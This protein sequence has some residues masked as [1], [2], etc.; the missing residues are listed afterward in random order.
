MGGTKIDV[1]LANDRGDIKVRTLRE[2]CA[3]EGRDLVIDRIIDAI[4]QV[5]S[6]VRVDA[7]GIGAAGACEFETGVITYSPNLPGWYNISL[8]SL[9]EAKVGLP[10]YLD[11]DAAVAAIGEHTFGAGIGIDHMILVTLGTGI[12]G[13]I[14][15]NGELYRGASGSAGEIGHMTIDLNGPRCS[16]GKKGCW[17]VL[18]SG[19]ALEREATARIE[20][21]EET[22]IERND[23]NCSAEVSARS[24]HKAALSGDR[25]ANELIALTSYYLGI[26]LVNLVNIFNPQLILIGGGLSN[27]G[28]MLID[29]AVETVREHAF[30]I[31]AKAARVEL[32]SLGGDA[33]P[34]GAV[35]LALRNMAR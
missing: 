20:A 35:A 12:G 32:S 15:I 11:N 22:S 31:S 1:V 25:L 5:S 13:G 24:V 28:A 29:P 3:S 33:G 27:M 6:G 17:E 30:E 2:T 21:G 26:G 4:K 7:I 9:I 16:C 23:P 14:I 18:A 10:T 34:L 19:S 8:K